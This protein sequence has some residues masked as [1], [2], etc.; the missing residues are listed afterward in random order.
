MDARNRN[1]HF[2]D[3]FLLRGWEFSDSSRATFASPL[4]ARFWQV[5]FPKGTWKFKPCQMVRAPIQLRSLVLWTLGSSRLGL[6][7]SRMLLDS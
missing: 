1:V 3:F 2:F 4:R 5:K 6:G 7:S